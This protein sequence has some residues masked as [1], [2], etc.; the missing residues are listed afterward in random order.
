MENEP[1]K[2]PKT[3]KGKIAKRGKVIRS[4]RTKKIA[5]AEAAFSGEPY[6]EGSDPQLVAKYIPKQPPTH[7]RGYYSKALGEAICKEVSLGLLPLNRICEKYGIDRQVF[8]D[9]KQK[10]EELNT[11]YASARLD[12]ADS[13]DDN[14]LEACRRVENAEFDPHQAK[15]LISAYQ[16]RAERLKP[17]VYGALSQMDPDKQASQGAIAR[18]SDAELK[19]LRGAY[20]DLLQKGPVTVIDVE[21]ISDNEPK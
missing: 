5:H 19:E 13:M 16:W 17:K 8:F 14:I 2:E 10:H 9:W 12:Q 4:A 15:V 21:A 20:R 1:P 7:P 6:R 11:L 18:M 3:L